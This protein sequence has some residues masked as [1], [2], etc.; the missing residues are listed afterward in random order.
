MISNDTQT[1]TVNHTE[2]APLP[3]S[4]PPHY[5]S[6]TLDNYHKIPEVA[7]LSREQHRAIQVVGTVLP[8]K[9]NNYVV[10]QLINWDDPQDPMFVLN[11]PQRDMLRPHHFEKM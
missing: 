9:V 2:Q 1:D 3:A 11:F 6:Y 4:R 5:Q 7:G 8:F 10:E